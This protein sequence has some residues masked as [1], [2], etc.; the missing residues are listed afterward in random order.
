MN[1]FKIVADSS[2]DFTSL[3]G[4]PFE[5]APLKILT[6]DKE[7]TDDAGLDAA[8]QVSEDTGLICRDDFLTHRDR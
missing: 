6:A 1:R 5:A 3:E 8:A 2:G 7:Y 4:V